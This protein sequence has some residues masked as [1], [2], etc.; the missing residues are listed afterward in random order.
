VNSSTAALLKTAILDRD[1]ENDHIPICW[2][3]RPGSAQIS[4]TDPY[5]TAGWIRRLLDVTPQK[6]RHSFCR[7]LAEA[8][9]PIE[10]IAEL[11]GHESIVVTRRYILPWEQHL[12]TAV[13]T[14][15]ARVTAPSV[16]VHPGPRINPILDAD[17]PAPDQ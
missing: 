10:V 2:K 7:R 11:A 6:L 17:V 16:Q 15:L 5:C 12:E 13:H 1:R 4:L 8:R 14:V 3:S 9:V